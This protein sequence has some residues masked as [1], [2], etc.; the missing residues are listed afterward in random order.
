MGLF[1]E[2]KITS[3]ERMGMRWWEKAVIEL[4]GSKNRAEVAADKYWGKQ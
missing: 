1:K 3:R 4:T 2:T